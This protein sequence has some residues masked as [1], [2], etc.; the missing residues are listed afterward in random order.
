MGVRNIGEDAEG[1]AHRSALE[2][3]HQAYLVTLFDNSIHAKDD[4]VKFLEKALDTQRLFDE[5]SPSVN[6][7]ARD[8][9]AKSK[10]P[11]FT[12]N[13]E[14]ALVLSA[15]EENSVTL[16]LGKVFLAD[17]PVY[18]FHMVSIVEARDYA[19]T[20]KVKAKKQLHETVDAEMADATK[21]SPSIQSMIDKAVTGRM[22]KLAPKKATKKVRHNTSFYISHS[23]SKIEFEGRQEWEEEDDFSFSKKGA[24]SASTLSP[25]G[26]AQAPSGNEDG[27]QAKQRQG[28]K[29]GPVFRYDIPSSYPD[30]L[31]TVPLPCAIDY[32]IL[33][34]PVNIVLA[35]Q[36]K[37][38]VHC[39][40]NVNLPLEIEQ[41]LNV[42]MNY[43]F[44]RKRNT[45]LIKAAWLNFEER[46]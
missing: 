34:M 3:A 25:Q 37:S 6:A 45:K 23:D 14:G 44:K 36:F 5:I 10:L 41:Q 38:H 7:R 40:P 13:H 8:I 16:D 42:G 11:V 1:A 30:W 28:Q 15:W 4:D 31:L 22:K 39:S 46:L 19:V 12:T 9:L 17:I 2:K 32:I 33:N 20:A 43:M 18:C 35:S 29:L 21:P 24:G 27:P 26:Q